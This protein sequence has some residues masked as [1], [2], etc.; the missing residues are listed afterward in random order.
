MARDRRRP[1][2]VKTASKPKP[3]TVVVAPSNWIAIERIGN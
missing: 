2:S 1:G 3:S